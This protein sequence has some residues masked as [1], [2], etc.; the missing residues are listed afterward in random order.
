MNKQAKLTAARLRELLHYDAT[1]GAFYWVSTDG[2]ARKGALAGNRNSNGYMVVGL[3]GV[4]YRQHRLA[5]LYVYGEWP[6]GVVDHIDGNKDNNKIENLRVVS[7]AQ[8]LQNRRSASVASACGV[9][10]VYY[11]ARRG[12]YMASVTTA[13]SK[14]RRGPYRSIERARIAYVDL[15]RTHHEACTI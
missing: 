11:S 4:K 15:K 2:R 7:Q 14:K 10:G 5:W 1:S 3:F 6:D 12:G 9:L 13:G 8:N